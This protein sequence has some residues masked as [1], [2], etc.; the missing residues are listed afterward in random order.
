MGGGGGGGG[1]PHIGAGGGGGGGTSQP[2][3]DGVCNAAGEPNNTT[4]A[5][6]KVDMA[7]GKD[8]KNGKGRVTLD[9]IEH[10]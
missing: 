10:F 5:G 3:D 9:E 1:A 6:G 2:R 7:A 8:K 4:G